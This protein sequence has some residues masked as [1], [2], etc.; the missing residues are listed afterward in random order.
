MTRSIEFSVY[1]ASF[2]TTSVLFVFFRRPEVAQSC[3]CASTSRIIDSNNL[4][5]ITGHPSVRHIHVLSSPP[6]PRERH[7]SPCHKSITAYS[8]TSRYL[9]S[10]NSQMFPIPIH[11]FSLVNHSSI[12]RHLVNL[13]N[14]ERQQ[15]VNVKWYISGTSGMATN[16][17]A[18]AYM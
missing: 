2:W 11:R 16:V 8:S 3:S 1:Q 4:V 10:Q 14:I 15:A 9:L 7:T 18:F 5:G 13:P 12:R 6:S 17:N